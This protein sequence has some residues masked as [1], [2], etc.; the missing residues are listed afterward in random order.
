M[1][2]AVIPAKKKA[3]RRKPGGLAAKSGPFYGEYVIVRVPA[4]LWIVTVMPC[5]KSAG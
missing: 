4:T 3:A 1:P 2:G 5:V